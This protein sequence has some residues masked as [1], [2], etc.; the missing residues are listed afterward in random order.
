MKR[1]IFALTV[2]AG[3]GM[4]SC[5][6]QD[7]N[8][9]NSLTE[10][11]VEAKQEVVTPEEPKMQSIGD[12]DFV[13]LSDIEKLQKKDS[14]MVLIDVYTDWCGPCKMMDK[15]TFAD[16]EVQAAIKK[17]FHMIKF[18]AE[19]NYTV[20][21][22]GQEYGNPNHTPNKRGRNSRHEFSYKLPVSAYPTILVLNE[23]LEIVNNIRGFQKPEQFVQ[24]LEAVKG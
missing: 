8:I 13:R 21:Y 23:D 14:K 18:N 7:A 5:D 6:N 11:K 9:S 24:S 16:P 1:L 17:D 22:K 19:G 20:N 3:I 15:I 12:L 10:Q 2:F 4:I